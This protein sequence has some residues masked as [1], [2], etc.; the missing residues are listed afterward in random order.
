MT[1]DFEHF[2]ADVIGR[3]GLAEDS[4]FRTNALRVKNRNA[5]YIV[6]E[7]TLGTLSTADVIARLDTA[8]IA[9]AR[10]NSVAQYLEHPQLIERG[11]WLDIGS[12]VGSLR[13]TVPPVHMEGVQPVLGDVPALGQRTDAILGELGIDRET[14]AAWRTEGAI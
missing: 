9:Y 1:P 3:P 11:C 7:S 2:C 13:A 6:M 8:G 12:P 4:R 5:L 10:M 14:I